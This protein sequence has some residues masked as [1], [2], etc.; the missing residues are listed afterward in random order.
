MSMGCAINGYIYSASKMS[1][2]HKKI[3]LNPNDWLKIFSCRGQKKLVSCKMCT[4]D[5]KRAFIEELLGSSKHNESG[6]RGFESHAQAV[7]LV[8]L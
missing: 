6:G 4:Y 8:I 2:C 3:F 1:F 7:S 5:F